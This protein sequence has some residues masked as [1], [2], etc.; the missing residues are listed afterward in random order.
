MENQKTVNV[1]PIPSELIVSDF[2][3]PEIERGYQIN[4]SRHTLYHT[5]SDM[6][7]H[8]A[9]L[10]DLFLTGSFVAPPIYG[11]SSTEVTFSAD[12]P[13][14]LVLEDLI[15][16]E[17]YLVSL[18]SFVGYLTGQVKAL[19]SSAEF[20]KD[21]EFLKSYNQIS[22]NKKNLGVTNQKDCENLAKAEIGEY[23]LTV[24]FWEN[25]F[26]KINAC[27]ISLERMLD[28]LKSM[29]IGKNIEMKVHR[30]DVI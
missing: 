9:N 23:A 22:K 25:N 2:N 10:K 1:Y 17:N 21:Q 6:L 30:L 15:G 26:Q 19:A 5:I 3:Y 29:Q 8:V 28:H 7:V 20:I 18:Y 24:I 27:R 4:K 11:F 16:C 12:E 14:V 13:R